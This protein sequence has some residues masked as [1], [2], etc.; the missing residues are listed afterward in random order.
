MLHG[1]KPPGERQGTKPLYENLIFIYVI[2]VLKGGPVW[3]VWVA[4]V[5]QKYS[6]NALIVTETE[7][8][9]SISDGN[10]QKEFK[11]CSLSNICLMNLNVGACSY[12]RALCL[13]CLLNKN[14]PSSTSR[15]FLAVDHIV[16][17]SEVSYLCVKM[18]PVANNYNCGEKQCDFRHRDR[19]AGKRRQSAVINPSQP[20]HLQLT[21]I[22]KWTHKE[23]PRKEWGDSSVVVVAFSCINHEWSAKK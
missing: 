22:P 8:D 23:L 1:S 12:S 18:S 20:A 4:A 6:V 14:S 7:K 16:V 9:F 15:Q 19:A 10:T 13:R 2:L 5:T 11:I 17:S 21:F 3:Q